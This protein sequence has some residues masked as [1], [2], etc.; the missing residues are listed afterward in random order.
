MT[1]PM[2]LTWDDKKLLLLW[3]GRLGS[4]LESLESSVEKVLIDSNP[5][6]R[7]GLLKC[8]MLS[9]DLWRE[10]PQVSIERLQEDLAKGVQE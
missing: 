2:R 4:V 6:T 9:M 8:F 10:K 3:I 7:A 1:E 5:I